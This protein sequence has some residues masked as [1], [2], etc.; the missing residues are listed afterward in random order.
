[1]PCTPMDGG[2]GPPY[3]R[4]MHPKNEIRETLAQALEQARNAGELNFQ[5]L[6]AFE[7]EAPKLAEHGDFATN[8]ALVLASQAKRS[9]RQIAEIIQKGITPPPGMLK[10]VEIA[11]PG[12]LNF[13][14]EDAYWC[15]VL[16]EIHRLGRARS[17]E[18]TSEL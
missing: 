11:G 17:E 6:P 9:P 14:I 5:S 2:H 13:F 12:L 10:K 4:N 16:P 7:V 3:K 18:H 15:R 8:A 1:M